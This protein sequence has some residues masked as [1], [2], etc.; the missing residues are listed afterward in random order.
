MVGILSRVKPAPTKQEVWE[1]FWTK[2]TAKASNAWEDMIGGLMAPGN[3][4]RGQYDQVQVMPDGSVSQFDPRMVQDA[5]SLAG[6]VTL[7]SGAIPRPV[8]TLNM[9]A[10]LSDLMERWSTAK[11]K[12]PNRNTSAAEMIE[13]I[14]ERT[15]TRQEVV[16]AL[17]DTGNKAIRFDADGRRALAG[18]DMSVPG[19][20]RLTYF[21]K[22][23][24]PDGH[25]EFKSMSEALDRALVDGFKPNVN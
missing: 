20:Y 19:G 22:D 6:M 24:V 16:T 18:P 1:N 25:S 9:G 23:G 21:D 4:L 3:A 17:L 5:S 11:A 15:K 10:N 12:Y 2:A 14:R 8:G 13:N 7:G